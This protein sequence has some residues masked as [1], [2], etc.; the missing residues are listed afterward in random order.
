MKSSGVTSEQSGQPAGDGQVSG[1]TRI[2]P[3]SENSATA[4]NSGGAPDCE[5]DD[6]FLP[7]TRFAIIDRILRGA[8]GQGAGDAGEFK[9]LLD[10]MAAWRHQS[11]RDRL[12]R[13]KQTYLPFSPDRDTVRI[14]QYT[15]DEREAMQTE[16]FEHIG[17]LLERANYQRIT[18][19]QLNELLTRHSP[20][21]LE[22][23]VDLDEFDRVMLFSRGRCFEEYSERS[24]WTLYLKKTTY[25]VPVFKRLFLLI[26]LKPEDERIEELMEEHD[27]SERKAARKLKRLRKRLMGRV[28]PDYIYL[29]MFK[30]I[31]R[32]DLEMLFPNTQVKFKLWDKIKLSVTAG[33][34]TLGSVLGTAGGGGKLLAA[35]SGAGLATMAP[36]ALASAL[37]GLAAVIYRQVTQFFF[38][39]TK[40]MME[41]ANR[42]YF[43][44]LADNRGA[45]TLLTD[46]AEEED[47]KEDMLLYF[48]LTNNPVRIDDLD[49]LDKRIEQFLKDEFGVTADF[50]MEDVAERLTGD[51]L[52][53][54]NGQGQLVARPIEDARAHLKTLLASSIITE[55]PV[56]EAGD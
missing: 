17:W 45:L 23:K 30:D 34:G 4:E 55:R 29:K 49:H 13:L 43:H 9:E 48:F 15:D 56:V 33:G 54:D 24:P 46:R 2:A 11:Y 6:H 28:S 14:L 36:M 38:Q 19:S 5:L 3:L 8:D 10:Y 27:I 39:R 35:A 12:L 25:Q 37:A 47:I 21:A 20:K 40:Y 42:L 7:L 52:I 32:E 18:E 31:P 53:F 41:L 16:L 26:K 50:D 1:D 51:G 44:S 22:L